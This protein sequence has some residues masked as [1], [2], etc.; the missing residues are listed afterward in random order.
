MPELLLLSGFQKWTRFNT[1]LTFELDIEFLL[2]S[3]VNSE[4]TL[5]PCSDMCPI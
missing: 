2:C 4:N 5:M 1:V 3:G